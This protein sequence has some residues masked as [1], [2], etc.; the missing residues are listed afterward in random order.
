MKIVTIDQMRHLEALAHQ[1]GVTKDSLIENA[2]LAVAERIRNRYGQVNR[3]AVVV[4]AGPGNNGGD[5]LVAARYLNNW[6]A[7]V[8]ICLYPDPY[9]AHPKLETLTDCDIDVIDPASDGGISTLRGA[10]RAADVVVDA[11]LGTGL[12][13]PIDGVLQQI[14]QELFAER[15]RRV[16][17]LLIAVDLPTGLDGNTG[18]ADSFC[19]SV[20]LTIALGF[21]KVGLYRFPGAEKVGLI[22]VVDIGIPDGFDQKILLELTTASWAFS[23]LPDRPLTAHKGSF[24]KAMVVAG[25]RE[26]IGA[27][28]LASSAAGRVG[29]GL[30]TLA[31]QQ[32]LQPAVALK[33][34]EPTYLILPELSSKN[35]AVK[36]EDLIRSLV[37]KG[38]YSS[39]LV[40]CGLGQAPNTVKMV[41][42][43][44]SNGAELPDTVV[45]ADGL[46][47]LS[48]SQIDCW[49]KMF[50]QLAIVTPHSAEMARLSRTTV[51]IIEQDRITSAREAA[52]TWNKVVVLKGP[53]TLVAT[54]EG[55][56]A[57]S[58]FANPILSTAGTGD[59]LAGAIAGLLAQGKSLEDAAILGVY[60]HGAAGELMCAHYGSSGMLASDLLP[61]L[62]RVIK[63]LRVENQS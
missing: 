15:V 8:I 48:G 45:D 22:E 21:P 57:V 62:P 2:G 31:I 37:A 59:V 51:E 1:A 41:K 9:H 39:L 4:L 11:L 47:I 18:M 49:W 6:G 17:L 58:P 46:N 38:G 14:L 61:T 12:S 27:A 56:V 54:P 5:G 23:E 50:P 7:R 60:L 30:V 35:P 55:K 10:L 43:L 26:Y 33:S 20:D 28:Y 32:S 19:S 13:R 34:V 29:A 63:K 53:Y 42:L 44:L 24:G 25:S 52:S 16:G 40:G 3:S 36:S